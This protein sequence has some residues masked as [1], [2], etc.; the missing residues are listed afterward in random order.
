M[1]VLVRNGK[2]VSCNGQKLTIVEQATKGPG[3]EV[4]KIEGLDGANGAKWISLKKLQEGKNELNPQAK[5]VVSTGSYTLNMAEKAEIDKL[6][7]RINEI[8]EAA[9]ARYVA[10]PKFVDPASITSE[11]VRQAEIKKVQEYLKSLRG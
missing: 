10:K 9:K 11:E 4:V 2:E 3:N 7:A 8:K 6:Q 5:Q 1:L